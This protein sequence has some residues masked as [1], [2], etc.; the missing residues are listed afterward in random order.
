MS[1][2]GPWHVL[3]IVPTDDVKAIR[4]AY[5]DKL[6]GMDV[7][8]D[9][10]GYA[11]L[12]Q[13]RD[14][15]LHLARQ[16]HVST[17]TALPIIAED[18]AAGEEGHEL[19]TPEIESSPSSVER[20]IGPDVALLEILFPNAEYSQ[21]PLSDEEWAKANAALVRIVGDAQDG[22]L[23][24]QHAVEMW[25]A[26][27]L[28]RAWPRSSMLLEHAAEAFDWEKQSGQIHEGPAQAF[29]NARLAGM[30]FHAMLESPTHWGHKA[31]R[32][33]STPGKKGLFGRFRTSE[34]EIRTLLAKIRESHPDLEAYL[35]QE[36]VQSWEHAVSNPWISAGSIIFFIFVTL[37]IVGMCS[38][39]AGRDY[40]DQANSPIVITGS[41]LDERRDEIARRVFGPE[42]DFLFVETHS[43][44]LAR[45]IT[46]YGE[47]DNDAEAEALV[48]LWLFSAARTAEFEQLVRIKE[49]KLDLALLARRWE[50]GEACSAFLETGRLPAR[51]VPTDEL[52]QREQSLAREFLQTGALEGVGPNSGES[53]ASVPGE[54]FAV[55]QR[56]SGLSRE[57]ADEVATGGG[58]PEQRCLFRTALMAEVLR[59]PGRVD[60]DLL[61]IL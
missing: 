11:A 1:R 35:D 13:A 38:R 53:R 52:R 44:P 39:I 59:Q 41:Q 8:Q 46:T 24:R 3:G 21:D 36:K 27:S 25:L 32:E 33:L 45:A 10:A 58:T 31:W 5:A 29:L 28:A 54:I 47:Q 16:N 22:E 20:I 40:E 50:G 55:A 60:V 14:A 43:A 57:K 19:P 61:R 26:D 9:A 18:M 23:V 56:V 7:D 42:T 49:L 6:R 2:R 51:I 4:K 12:R 37:Q 30:R 34:H 15:T 48:R 17:D